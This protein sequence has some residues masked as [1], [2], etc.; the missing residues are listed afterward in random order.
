ML[1][2]AQRGV[3]DAAARNPQPASRIPHPASERRGQAYFDEMTA[4]PE[5]PCASRMYLAAGNA[6]W[7]RRPT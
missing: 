1:G 2:E 4:T 5:D 7:A 3:I 6:K